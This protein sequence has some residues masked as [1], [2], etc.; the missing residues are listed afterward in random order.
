MKK[1]L[2]ALAALGAFA[3]AASA[4]SSVTVFGVVDL[5]VNYIENKNAAGVS[6]KSY[7]LASNQLNS[8]RLG[9]RGVE[10]LGG[11]LQA[12]FWL[13]AGMNNATGW[14]GG[15]SGNVGNGDAASSQLF[16][17][18]STVSLMSR[19]GELR[20]GRDY[21]PS[22]WNLVFFDV[23][24]ANGLGQALNLVS[25]LGSGV[26]TVARTNNSIGYFLPG[27]L[28][29]LY[30]QAQYALGQS[31]SGTSGN[32]YQG[33]RLGWASGP[34]DVAGAWSETETGPA[35]AA[36]S[37]A[38]FEVMNFGAS[39]D[40]KIAKVYGVYNEYK[41]D[42][43]KQQTWG[44][45]VGVPLGAG[46]FRAAYASADR[47]GNVPRGASI[48]NDDATMWSV[49][50]VYNLSKRTALYTTYG[51]IDN[52]GAADFKVLGGTN[53]ASTGGSSKGFNFG[54]RHSF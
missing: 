17:R 49:E 43:A 4:Q 29:G 11:G 35:A 39:W 50:Y 51:Q 8:N 54:M 16:N 42:S 3:G 10:D 36:V 32:Q 33:F 1:S 44:V 26:S 22:F 27:G 5:S 7:Y 48:E 45:S 9:F 19:W 18:R 24:G 31:A 34:F 6:N 2:L 23:N 30:G 52:E 40:F 20:L 53:G 47:K 38:K 37:G 15:G 14:A 41:W 13:E 21:D 28:G 12:G 46:E 25:P